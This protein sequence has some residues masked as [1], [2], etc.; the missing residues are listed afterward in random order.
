MYGKLFERLI[1]GSILTIL[2]YERVN[3]STNTKTE[4]VFWLSDSQDVRE[5]DATLIVTPEK[6]VRFDIGFIGPGNS[7]I[8]KDKL[9]RWTSE[10]ETAGGTISSTTFII[11]DRLPKSGKTQ[12]A[13]AKIGAVIIEMS[14]PHWVR[15]LALGLGER[16]GIN[17]ELQTMSDDKISAYLSSRLT[18]IPVQD[19]LSGVST[20]TLT[21]EE[22]ANDDDE[23]AE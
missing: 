7:E 13:A 20:E 15:D 9:S 21:A 19:F 18:S 1:L 10:I 14:D 11:I 22:T 23:D 2:G 4:G 17:H 12:S 16:F 3:P 6:R 8:S 5:S